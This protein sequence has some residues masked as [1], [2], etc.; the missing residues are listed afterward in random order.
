M[1]IPTQNE[2]LV[3]FLEVLGDGQPHTRS[4]ILFTLAKRFHLSE[5]ELNDMSG[6]QFTM[7]NR[8][9]WCDAYFVKA[10]F[11]S[12]ERDPD[13]SFNDVFR[14]TATG[15]NQLKRHKARISVGYL[16]SFY[17]GKVYRGAGSGDTTSA[18]EMDLYERLNNLGGDFVAFHSVAWIGQGRRSVGEIDFLIAHPDYGVL[19]LEVKGG[20]LEVRRIGNSNQWYSRDRFGNVYKIS[21]PCE[22]AERNRRELHN[23]LTEHNTTTRRYRYALFPAVAAPDSV[24]R[25]DIRM[26]C[27]AAIFIDMRHLDDLEARLVK[28]FEYWQKHTDRAN[29]TMS[30]QAA[31]DALVN[32]LVPQ[33]ALRPRIGDV[34][35]RERQ[36]IEALTE[37]QFRIL[38]GLQRNRRAVIVGGAGTGKTM[39]AMEKAQQ[40]AEDGL[41][42]LFL[43][44]N[45]NIVEWIDKNLSDE[46]IT[47]ATYHSFVGKAQHMAGMQ[48]SFRMGWDE[49]I[50]KSPEL[51]MDAAVV[52]RE[53]KPDELFD[54]IIVDEAQD[55]TDTMWIP[56]LDWLKD[57]ETGIFYIFFDDNQR[58]YTQISNIPMDDAARFDLVENCRN[59][60]RIHTTMMAYAMTEGDAYCEGPEGRDVEVIPVE[61]KDGAK[62]KLQRL[63]HRLVN[64]ENVR[65]EDIVI[66]SVL[67]E[68]K[69]MWQ[70]DEMLGNFVLTWDMETDMNQAVRLST[71]HA[72]KGLESAVVILTELDRLKEHVAQ[73]LLYV[74]LSRA[75]HHAVVLGALPA[76][77]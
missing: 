21:D 29:K 63:L 31:V 36:K 47:V 55:F 52:T 35:E 19:V 77:E 73:Q 61:D 66:L 22:Q 56:L 64:E 28:I 20:G 68:R 41:R 10:G 58:I 53:Q 9:G 71:I 69:S 3:P 70:S 40:L 5:A 4:E 1:P 45:R 38:R 27:P 13:D 33:R 67:S 8:V 34:F 74:G 60:Q 39:L 59:T 7:V 44:Y 18:A 24:V 54:A 43:A 72:F 23:Y 17:R 12:K 65:T 57:P 75:R 6:N 62:Q 46:Q 30:G 76:L 51:L 48:D 16:Q 49:F 2:I 15:Q 50:E 32:A 37:Q 11:V 26:D 14:I 25:E 42:V